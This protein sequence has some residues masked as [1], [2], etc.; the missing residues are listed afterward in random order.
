MITAQQ[1][2]DNREKWA[3]A[4]ESDKYQQCQQ[5]MRNPAGYCCLGVAAVVIGLS[6]H[7]VERPDKDHLNSLI[8]DRVDEAMGLTHYE[9]AKFASAN[10]NDGKS[11]KEIAKMV[12]HLFPPS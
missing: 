3:E 2:L 9:R 6:P 11:F 8:Y 1:I 4:L 7:S 10:D 12:R 5:V